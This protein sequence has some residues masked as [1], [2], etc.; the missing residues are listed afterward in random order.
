MPDTKDLTSTNSSA[1][2]TTEEFN[3][4][5]RKH[6]EEVDDRLAVL[7]EKREYSYGHKRQ[8]IGYEVRHWEGEREEA[9]LKLERLKTEDGD[10]AK[11]WEHEDQEREN[12]SGE[13]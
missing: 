9:V 11:R 7:Y 3:A 12:H 1:P 10:K 2:A 6:L 13:M 5:R 8:L 4:V